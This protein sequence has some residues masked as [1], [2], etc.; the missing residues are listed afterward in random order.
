MSGLAWSALVR[1]AKALSAFHS[2]ETRAT[3]S[4]MSVFL[5]TTSKKPSRRWMA[6]TSPRSPIMITAW[7]LVPL[8]LASSTRNCTVSAA[9]LRLSAWIA[10]E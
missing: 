5:S 3:T 6:F 7:R 4:T 2:V 1:P 9:I 8:F 10:T